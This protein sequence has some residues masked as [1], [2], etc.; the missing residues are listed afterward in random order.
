MFRR[1]NLTMPHSVRKVGKNN[2]RQ[3]ISNALLGCRRLLYERTVLVLTLLFCVGMVCILWYMSHLQSNLIT[4]MALQDASLYS[5]A[6]AEF[7]ALYTSE[8]VETVKDR[9]IEVTHDYTTKEGAIPLPA[10]LSMLLAGCGKTR[11]LE[12]IAQKSARNQKSGPVKSMGYR[13]A[14]GHGLLRKQHRPT[15]SATC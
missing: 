8:V 1:P 4:S 14:E 13:N 7:R 6:L 11:R 5:Q 9:G 12:K 15:F 3:A 2:I 10:T